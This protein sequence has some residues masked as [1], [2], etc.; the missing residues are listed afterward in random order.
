MNS[1]NNSFEKHNRN[2]PPIIYE[3]GWLTQ[4]R[5]KLNITIKYLDKFF[6]T[7]FIQQTSN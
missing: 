7:K 2:L 6:G 5:N 4:I 1:K 3:D